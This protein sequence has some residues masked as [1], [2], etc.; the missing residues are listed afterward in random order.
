MTRMEKYVICLIIMGILT[1]IGKEWMAAHDDLKQAQATIA[2]NEQQHK[3]EIV[4]LQNEMEVIKH[5]KA[6]TRTPEQI[7]SKLPTYIP[8]PAP[9]RLSSGNAGNNS[10][11]Q[12]PDIRANLGGIGQTDAGAIIPTASLG[13]LFNF[14]TDCQACRLQHTADLAKIEELTKERDAA[15]KAAKGGSWIRRVVKGA[16]IFGVGLGIGLAIGA[17]HGL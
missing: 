7:I 14:A 12:P 4:T 16:K 17:T 10:V 13:P 2:L 5:D 15:L 8:L 3:Q 11:P 1:F 6:T 9:I